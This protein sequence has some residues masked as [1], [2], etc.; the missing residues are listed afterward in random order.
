MKLSL[1]PLIPGALLAGA[2]GA[3]AYFAL[4]PSPRQAPASVASPGAPTPRMTGPS[5]RAAL[6]NA[7]TSRG[8]E[9]VLQ[10]SWG[11]GPGEIGRLLP[12]EAS[13][14]GPM[15]FA[16][17]RDGRVA[18]LDQVNGRVVVFARGEDAQT[19]A[20][21]TNTYQDIAI[22]PSGGLVLMDRLVS[23]ALLFLSSRGEVR[24]QVQLEGVGVR[25]GGSVTALFARP[26]GAWV[27]VDHTT[28]VRV[29][30][31][32]GSPDPDR[33]TVP[34][35][36]GAAE[37][38]FIRAAL[39]D[40]QQAAVSSVARDGQQTPLARVELAADALQLCALEI[41][42]HGRVFLGATLFREEPDPPYEARG[43]GDQVIVL[44]PTGG[45]IARVL[46][47]PNPGPEE[48]LR[49]LRIGDDGAIYHLGLSD[50]GVTLRRYVP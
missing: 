23:R 16:V 41:D 39:L 48:Q 4:A 30:L 5:T 34:G 9:V 42:A 7:G 27:E 1:S 24:H 25:D 14:E 50:E 43:L 40:P 20:L 21:P 8:V 3:S 35:R 10:A 47:P 29:T 31:A 26:D 49:R 11:E 45:E 44:S 6:L 22:E 28:L 33:A 17:D 46:F 36:F 13:A 15:S 12:Q 19:V 2:L 18:I 32:D 37:G 38:R